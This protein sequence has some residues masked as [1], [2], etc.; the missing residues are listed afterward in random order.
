MEG[1]EEDEASSLIGV[2]EMTVWLLCVAVLWLCHFHV[3]FSRH[4]QLIASE[5]VPNA[6]V[7]SVV[8]GIKEVKENRSK[9]EQVDVSVLVNALGC[10]IERQSKNIDEE[11]SV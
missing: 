1:D 6:S 7:E 4:V 9:Y 3:G 10:R 2:H 5:Q 8:A 11:P